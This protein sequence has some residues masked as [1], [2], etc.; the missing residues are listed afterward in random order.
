MAKFSLI[1][2]EMAPEQIKCEECGCRKHGREMCGV[3]YWRP[4]C[5]YPYTCSDQMMC[6]CSGDRETNIREHRL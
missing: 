4:C 3:F 1:S 2:I 5:G 6:E